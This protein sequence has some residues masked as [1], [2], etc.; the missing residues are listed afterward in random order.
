MK[1]IIFQSF[2]TENV[3]PWL[4]RCRETVR[5][6]AAAIGA[7]YEFIDDSL[8]DSVPGWY[9][10]TAK[11]SLTVVTDL[12]RLV[13][14]RKYLAAGYERAVWVDADMV[15]FAPEHLLLPDDWPFVF[16]HEVWVHLD[17]GKTMVFTPKT[18]NAL[19]A[20]SASDTQFLDHYIDACEIVI[21]GC[22]QPLQGAEVGTAWLT[23]MQRIMKFPVLRNIAALSPLLMQEIAQGG[24]RLT[25]HF[26]TRA[27]G[28][29]GAANLCASFNGRTTDGVILSDAVFD[30]VIDRLLAT[31]G[32]VLNRWA[33][34][35]IQIALARGHLAMGERK[36]AEN[37]LRAISLN[38]PG[39]SEPLTLLAELAKE[40]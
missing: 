8:F 10:E 34:F 14:A 2:R 19:C 13:V 30:R 16:C 26:V 6:W 7:D 24:D 37:L 4:D 39:R 36:N 31:R 5:G 22:E 25:A 20:F 28:V 23:A 9:F 21:R 15:V 11:N 27:G 3:S 33:D 40:P 17:G 35:D 29:M 12:A 1:T 18:N 32:D 38:A